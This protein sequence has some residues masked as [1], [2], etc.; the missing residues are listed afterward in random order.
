MEAGAASASL[1]GSTPGGRGGPPPHTPGHLITL[2]GAAPTQEA[3][4]DGDTEEETDEVMAEDREEKKKETKLALFK[5][6]LAK[7]IV[8]MTE[9]KKGGRIGQLFRR[10]NRGG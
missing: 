10:V 5:G 6:G 2:F 3:E 4:S 7:K 9:D 1:P 8:T